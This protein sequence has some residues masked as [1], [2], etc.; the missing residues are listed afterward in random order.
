MAE[1][2]INATAAAVLGLLHDGP[3][4]GGQLMAA[5]ER[6][7][8]PYWSMTRSQVYRE[9]PVLA[10][11]G[12]VKLGKPGP[13]A[14]QPY[15]ITASGK[16]AFARWLNEEP[17]RELV[18][19]PYALRVAFGST[20]ATNQFDS[21]LNSANTHHTE[22]LA[23]AREQAKEAKKEGDEFT[24]AGLEFAVAYHKAAL[25]WLKSA[26]AK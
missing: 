15:A 6:R 21:L 7:L 8:S 26:I 23:E 16:R 17:G 19:N 20:H 12:Y 4:T 18:R 10:E 3:M 13:R 2:G 1:V 24:A 9:L 14:S 5:A 22:A 25:N 11:L